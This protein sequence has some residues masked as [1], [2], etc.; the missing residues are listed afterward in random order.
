MRKVYPLL[1]M[2]FGL[3][4][5]VSAQ[6]SNLASQYSMYMLNKYAF[7]PAYAGLDNSLSLTGVVRTQWTG[8]EGNPVTQNANAHLPLY[9]LRGGFGINIEN[10]VLGAERNTSASASYNFWLP[11]SEK[12]ILTIGM[13][14]GITQKSLDGTKLRSPGG[15]YSSGGAINHRD[16]YIP[17]GKETAMVPTF[18]AGIYYQ[19]PSIEIG[20]STNNFSVSNFELSTKQD[21]IARIKTVQNYFAI[22]AGKFTV[23]DKVV[24][25]PS[26]L[27]KSDFTQTQVEFSTIVW[28]DD[29]IFGGASFR[30]YESKSVDAFAIIAGF[31]VNEHITLAYS[32]D[33]SLSQLNTVNGGSHEVIINYNLNRPIGAGRLPKIIY[34]PRFL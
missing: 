23:G 8:L 4:L 10:E 20:I 16:S 11:I 21:T 31:K 22:F 34:N 12:R 15:Q 14:G 2:L 26:L 1:F 25:Q 3:S 9:I 32:Y 30:G 7:N 6:Q 27:A 13:G 33:V 17:L 5:V 28:Y 18:S 24:V 19:S 29:N